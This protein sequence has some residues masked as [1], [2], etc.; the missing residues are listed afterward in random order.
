MHTSTSVTAMHP[1]NA[2]APPQS[3]G[4]ENLVLCSEVAAFV[5]AYEGRLRVPLQQRTQYQVLT[6]GWE[7]YIQPELK[8]L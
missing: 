7:V 6:L 8:G 4:P 1:S 5:P 3:A 2:Y